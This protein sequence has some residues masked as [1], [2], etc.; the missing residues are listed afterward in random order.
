MM[1]T[2]PTSR[3]L[4]C[5]SAAA[6]V[7]GLGACSSSA[8]SDTAPSTGTTTDPTF[9]EVA[10]AAELLPDD[11][12][13]TGELHVAIPTNEPPTQFYREGT[14]QMTGINP[15]I[16]RLVAGALGLDIQIEVVNFDSIIP[17]LEAGRYDMTV[18]SM[19]P[20]E[21]RM[22]VLDFVE[23]MNVGSG[24]VVLDSNPLDLDF[25]K[26]CGQKVAVLTGSYQMTSNVP[27]LNKE[28]EAAGEQDLE[29]QQFKDTRQAISSLTSGRS[30]AVYADGP[31]LAY[32]ALQTSE[33]ELVGENNVDAVAIGVPQESGLL[34]PLKAAMDVILESPEYQDVLESYGVD[35]S[36]ITDARINVAQ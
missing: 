32:A 30:D 18:S 31:I 17:G 35:G 6:L 26:L 20:T 19:T 23:Y 3:A 11:I 21:D 34:D 33:I 27:E 1:F 14:K 7:L 5:V 36:A 15:D 9:D 12:A 24:L 4:V 8:E 29:I 28:C 2:Q 10:D 13:D 22:K 16:A 25:D